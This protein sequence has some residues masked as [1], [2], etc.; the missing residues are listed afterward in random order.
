MKVID[1]AIKDNAFIFK[2]NAGLNMF[3][4]DKD[5]EL[6]HDYLSPDSTILFIIACKETIKPEV[7]SLGALII[8][9]NQIFFCTKPF[10]SSPI[11]EG[12]NSNS[13]AEFQI[14]K[15]FFRG[16]QIYLEWVSL[17]EGVELVNDM[18]LS[19]L[20]KDAFKKVKDYLTN[21]KITSD[22]K[23]NAYEN[24]EQ[25]SDE[26]EIKN[27]LIRLEKLLNDN[28]ITNEEFNEKRNEILKN[29]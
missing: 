10:F 24:S 9:T 7:D 19:G 22:I 28:L 29:I 18:H 20:N 15:S 13:L 11:I 3:K 1:K 21:L 14:K 6:V 25:K 8:T 12:F 4:I 23:I 2:K 27:K 16:G 5:I 17:K 26:D